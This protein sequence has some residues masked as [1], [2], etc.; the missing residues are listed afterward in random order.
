M[1]ESNGD[2]VVVVVVEAVI[3]VDGDIENA[4]SGSFSF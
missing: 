1:L 4:N 2:D 3:L